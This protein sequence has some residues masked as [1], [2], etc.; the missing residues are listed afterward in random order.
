MPKQAGWADV[1]PPQ[2]RNQPGPRSQVNLAGCNQSKQGT[3]F[4]AAQRWI[5]THNAQQLYSSSLH[6]WLDS[7]EA[8]ANR[9]CPAQLFRLM[10]P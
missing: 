1:T 6:S 10:A 3:A 4:V 7:K 5:R 9:F 2:A 8:S